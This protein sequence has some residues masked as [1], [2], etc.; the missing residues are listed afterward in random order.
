MGFWHPRE[1]HPRECSESSRHP[2]ESLLTRGN[3]KKFQ[4]DSKLSF[5][6]PP[7]APLHAILCHLYTDP[8]VFIT[9]II[10]IKI[11]FIPRPPGT[12]GNGTRGNALR[13]CGTRGNSHDSR[14]LPAGIRYYVWYWLLT[15]GR[16]KNNG[17]QLHP[18]HS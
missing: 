17:K 11:F 18:V 2:R 4:N 14:G 15:G 6:S 7:Q 16:K 13:A 1:R 8:T 3:A 12:R 5:M 10:V 9:L